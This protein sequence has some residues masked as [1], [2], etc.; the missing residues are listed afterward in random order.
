MSETKDYLVQDAEK[1]TVN[2]SEEVVAQS[3]SPETSQLIYLFNSH[4]DVNHKQI[5]SVLTKLQNIVCQ[6]FHGKIIIA[7]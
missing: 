4:A 1:G 3:L 2:I 6:I 7:I 5:I